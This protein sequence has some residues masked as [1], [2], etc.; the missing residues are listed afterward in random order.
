MEIEQLKNVDKKEMKLA[1]LR[2][3]PE[4]KAFLKEHMISLTTLVSECIKELREK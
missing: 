4:D 3:T 1:T 2:I